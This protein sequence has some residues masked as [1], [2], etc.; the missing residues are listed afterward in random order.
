MFEYIDKQSD[1]TLVLISGWAFDW[2]VFDGLNIDYN[3]L[4]FKSL[5]M[6]NLIPELSSWIKNSDV[7]K[8][9]ILGWSMGGYVAAD[10]FVQNPESVDKLFLVGIKP[11]YDLKSLRKI[12]IMLKRNTSAYMR[13][14]YR[15]CFAE[16]EQNL[17][18]DAEKRLFK[19]YEKIFTL[20]ILLSTL[21]WLGSQ[22]LTSEKLSG[23]EKAT[24]IHGSEDKIAYFEEAK[25]LAVE[26]NVDFKMINGAGHVLFNNSEFRDILNER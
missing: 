3:L 16:S 8:V 18:F 7:K 10:F 13:R 4:L 26:A 9:S 15:D 1:R 25:E 11:K 5:D 22:K 23:I 12:Q 2:R 14:F 19:S 24:I 20:E 21:D 17:L 6:N